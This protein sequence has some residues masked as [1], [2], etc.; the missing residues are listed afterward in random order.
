MKHEF[1][2][3]PASPYTIKYGSSLQFVFSKLPKISIPDYN[4]YEELPK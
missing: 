1:V 4:Y 2:T 3:C